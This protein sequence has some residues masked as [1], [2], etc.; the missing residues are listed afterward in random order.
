MKNQT[1]P[2]DVTVHA[3]EVHDD[4]GNHLRTH[5]QPGGA[6]GLTAACLFI[7]FTA[8]RIRPA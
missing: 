6:T 3:V 8:R 7:R 2:P 1:G 4:N 5:L